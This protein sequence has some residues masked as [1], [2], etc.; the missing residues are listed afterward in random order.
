MRLGR[1]GGAIVVAAGTLSAHKAGR[2]DR[3]RAGLI[4]NGSPARG[5]IPRCSINS[6]PLCRPTAQRYATPAPRPVGGEPFYLPSLEH[7]NDED[8]ALCCDA[9]Y[10]PML[11][12]GE[13]KDRYA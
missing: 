9:R 8:N 12:I 10:L 5:S 3:R 7:E 4:L 6:K 13:S 2:D 1:N 11:S